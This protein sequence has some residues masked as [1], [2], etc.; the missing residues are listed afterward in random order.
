M[1]FAMQGGTA[2]FRL[3]ESRSTREKRRIRETYDKRL[4]AGNQAAAK[5]LRELACEA[6]AREY[7]AGLRWYHRVWFR[8]QQMF[9]HAGRVKLTRG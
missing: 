5:A 9:G 7:E 6:A 4:E 1:A 3:R 2:R 8:V